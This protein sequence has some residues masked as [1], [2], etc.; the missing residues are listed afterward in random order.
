M[1]LNNSFIFGCEQLGGYAWGDYDINEINRSLNKAFDEEINIFDTADCYGQGLS[2]IRLGELFRKK[3]EEIVICTKGGV[4]LLNQDVIY[5]SSIKWL[6]QAVDNSLKRLKTDYIDLY[7]I[8]YWDGKEQIDKIYDFLQTLVKKGKILNYG[9]CN[10]AGADIFCDNK[11]NLKTFSLE[12]SLAHKKYEEF[13]EKKIKKFDYF[14]AYGCLAQG[15]LT[16]K[17]NE[18]HIFKK[19]DRRSNSKY[20]NFHGNIFKNNLKIVKAIKEISLEINLPISSLAIAWIKYKNPRYIPIVGIKNNNQLIEAL[21]I[22][23]LKGKKDI[24]KKLDSLIKKRFI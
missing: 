20:I 13:I 8:H 7:Q 21:K 19:S 16:G 23:N 10:Y 22:K 15:A 18:E 9:I 11:K 2:E 17:Y 1:F 14:L 24:F 4:R 3:R 6:E 5:D 12:Y